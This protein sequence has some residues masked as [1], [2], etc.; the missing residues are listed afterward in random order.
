MEVGVR[1]KLC[2]C[3]TLLLL[4]ACNRQ[5]KRQIAVI[6]KGTAHV[7]WQTVH[8]GANAAGQE[9][10][11]EI[12]WNGPPAETDYSRQI[13]IMDSMIARHVSGIALAATDR[14]ALD[15]SIERAGK[16][17]IPVTVFD[18]GVAS[19]NYQTFVATDNFAGGQAGARKL[20]ELIGGKG[21]VGLVAN[22]PGS[23]ST[24][25]REAG[26]KDA[27]SKEF[28]KIKIVAEQFSMSDRA[29]G[30]AATENILTAHPGLAGIFASAEPASVAAAQALKSRDLV[31]K[32]RLVGFDSG[33]VLVADLREGTIDALVA[34]DPFKMGFEAVRTVV[35]A[36]D[37]K[38]PP[39]RVDLQATVITKAD[40]DKPEIKALLNPDLQKYL[41]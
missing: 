7:F 19:T 29:K 32:V 26:F 2:C 11:V 33:D 31:G 39:K 8:A 4:T 5:H 13:E 22:A 17:K 40:L 28:P 23:V 18:S 41:K 37:G 21:Q 38:T 12:L 25:D 1:I 10:N 35:E 15:A 27:L 36:L 20:A 24:M 14:N 34:Q 3:A 16:Q 30:L 6:P 9:F